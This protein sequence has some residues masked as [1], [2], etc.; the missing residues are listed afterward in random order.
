MSFYCQVV[1]E[2]LSDFCVVVAM[3]SSGERELYNIRKFD[4]TNFSLWKEQIKN[5]LV[6]K[7]QLKPISWPTAKPANMSEED[8]AELDALAKLTIRLHL[9]ESV[10]FIVVSKMSSFNLWKKLCGT[11]EKETASNKVYLMK[12]LFEL[13]TK[14]STSV[15]SH[16]NEFNIIFSYMQ[17]QKLAFGDEV[18]AIFLLCSS[19]ASWDTFRTTISNSAPDGTLTFNDVVGSLLAEKRYAGN[20]WIRVRMVKH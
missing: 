1:A 3:C 16:L 13:Q 5:I 20:Q 9:A 6:Q 4:G 15:A 7:R 19:L 2:I 11:Y 12:R 14:E 18:K 8:W 17:V 10:Y